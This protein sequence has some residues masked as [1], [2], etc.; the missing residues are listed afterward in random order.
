[1]DLDSHGFGPWALFEHQIRSPLALFAFLF[2]SGPH[3]DRALVDFRRSAQYTLRPLMAP[4]FHRDPKISCLLQP[5]LSWPAPYLSPP[6]F[7]NP[8]NRFAGFLLCHPGSP[9]GPFSMRRAETKDVFLAASSKLSDA[10]FFVWH[11]WRR[12]FSHS[13]API[14]IRL[15]VLYACP[16]SRD[17]F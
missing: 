17:K 15:P 12:M 14:W 11:L 13:L 7:A 1:M 4:N 2:F 10:I 16:G 5:N 3:G 9:L 6:S 8:A